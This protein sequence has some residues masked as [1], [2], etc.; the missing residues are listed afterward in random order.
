MNYSV[1]PENPLPRYYQVYQSLKQRIEDGEFPPDSALPAERQLVVDYGVSRITIVKALDTLEIE[2]LIWREHGRGT[3]VKRLE[4]ESSSTAN[5][6]KVIGFLP[7]GILHPFHYSMQLG[8][9]QVAMEH[10]YLLQVLGL[11]DVSYDVVEKALNLLLGRVDGLITYPRPNRKD[12]KLYER[13]MKLNIPFVMADRYYEGIEADYVGY[14]HEQAGYE[15]TRL[16]LERGHTR[17]AIMPHFEVN[18]SSI[19]A[20]F[21][22]YKRAMYEAGITDIDNLIWLDVYAKYRPYSGQQGNPAMTQSLLEKIQ[23][24]KP[25]AFIGANDDVVQRLTYDLMV[26][27]AE[28]AK[29][30]IAQNGSPNFELD[31]EVASF[32]VQPPENYGTNVVAVAYQP[33]E[34]TGREAAN[35]LI[36]RLNGDYDGPPRFVKIPVEIMIRDD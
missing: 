13:L 18:V 4:T 34:L 24:F 10:H 30:A 31:I 6:P 16:M 22:G 17:I 19:H 1:D 26:I 5:E 29:V 35:M 25:T 28:R 21:A 32:A 12:I 36:S 27:N 23:K 14:E 7:S 2:G 20:R 33:G 9:A 3:F 15:L 8:I 11:E